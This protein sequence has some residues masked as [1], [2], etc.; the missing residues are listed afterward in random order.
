MYTDVHL[1][2]AVYWLQELVIFN[3]PDSVPLICSYQHISI[4]ALA[5]AEP[6][7]VIGLDNF[8]EPFHCDP[9]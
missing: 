2:S 5:N 4:V 1:V 3:T 8:L 7:L 9:L 6:L